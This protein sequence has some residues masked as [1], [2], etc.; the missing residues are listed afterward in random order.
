MPGWSRPGGPVASRRVGPAGPRSLPPP[1]LVVVVP[2]AGL[3]PAPPSRPVRVMAG[4]M[5]GM[6]E[7]G[8]QP[9]DLGHRRAAML[10]DGDRIAAIAWP[11]RGK[12]STGRWPLYLCRFVSSTLAVPPSRPIAASFVPARAAGVKTGRRP[13]PAGRVVLTL[14]AGRPTLGGRHGP[15]VPGSVHR[16][17]GQGRLGWLKRVS[18]APGLASIRETAVV[19]AT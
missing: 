15:K 16:S 5:R 10:P 12:L 17:S 18:R 19:S 9:A 13:R 8:V 7:D 14:A 1:P 6:A 3:M 2:G 4:R 11:G